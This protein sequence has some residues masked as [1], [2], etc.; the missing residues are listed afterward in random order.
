MQHYDNLI[1]YDLFVIQLFLN[2][3]F[4]GLFMMRIF[5]CSEVDLL[6]FHLKEVSQCLLRLV[7]DFA[8]LNLIC[9]VTLSYLLH[10]YELFISFF[11][12]VEGSQE[13]LIQPTFDLQVLGE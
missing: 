6:M 7:K 8:K 3:V 12:P 11:A 1:L 4:F 9:L 13:K 5:Y 10:F 2:L